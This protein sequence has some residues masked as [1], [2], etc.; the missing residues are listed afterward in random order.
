MINYPEID[1][2]QVDFNDTRDIEGFAILIFTMANRLRLFMP[3]TGNT[4]EKLE[5]QKYAKT[6]IGR[7]E[8]NIPALSAGDSLTII[9]VYDLVHRIAFNRAA[10]GNYI[11][12]HKLNAFDAYL[13]GDKTVNQYALQ[14]AVSLEIRRGNKVFMD[15]PLQWECRCLDR[16]HKQFRFGKSFDQMSDYDTIQRV[17]SLLDSDLWAF[18]TR[19]ES[20]FKQKLF[21]NHRHYLDETERLDITALTALDNFLCSSARYLA[22]GEFYAYEESISRSILQHPAANRYLKSSIQL[23]LEDNLACRPAAIG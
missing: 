11:N 17:K 5:L 18:E 7:V 10:N 4:P 8:D 22:P 21:D 13:R 9:G 20:S 1:I 23:R 2:T 19:N 3:A 12:K 15:K 6:W 16:W 14:Q